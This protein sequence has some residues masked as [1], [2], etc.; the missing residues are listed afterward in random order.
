MAQENVP[1]SGFKLD[2][3]EIIILVAIL[4]EVVSSRRN[5][6]EREFKKVKAL[7]DLHDTMLGDEIHFVGINKA[8]GESSTGEEL[9]SKMK[10]D[11]ASM[12]KV[13]Q[14]LDDEVGMMGVLSRILGKLRPTYELIRTTDIFDDVVKRM[15]LNQESLP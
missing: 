13:L 1:T 3:Q 11:M 14:D 15:D 9:I 4:N 12:R 8:T 2:N 10:S 5:T 7:T 6:I